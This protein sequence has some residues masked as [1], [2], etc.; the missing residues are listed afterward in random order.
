MA[1]RFEGLTDKEWAQLEYLFP[2]ASDN[3]VKECLILLL[4]R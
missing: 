3:V 2:N 4:E 1:G